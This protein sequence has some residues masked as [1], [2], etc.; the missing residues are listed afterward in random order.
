[1][2][3]PKPNGKTE[4]RGTR[5]VFNNYKDSL[6]IPVINTGTFCNKVFVSKLYLKYDMNATRK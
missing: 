5:A 3:R 4:V 2:A 6:S 1:M